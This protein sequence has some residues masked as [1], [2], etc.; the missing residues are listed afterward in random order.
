M[1]SEL[2]DEPNIITAEVMRFDKEKRDNG[3]IGMRRCDR[4]GE[5]GGGTN[6][7]SQGRALIRH[8]IR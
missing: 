5:A 1:K 6:E 3:T 8:S 7:R 4:E 2:K